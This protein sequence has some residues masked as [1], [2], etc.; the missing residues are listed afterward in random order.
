MKCLV[1]LFLTAAM[2]GG[3]VEGG[4]D[5]E[6]LF[7]NNCGACHGLERAVVGPSL[8]DIR[9]LYEGKEG[10]FVAWAISPQKKRQNVIE[11]PSMVHVGEEGLRAIYGYV[12]KI[13]KG[14][15]VQEEV[16][17]D[18]FLGTPGQLVRPQIQRIFL[19]DAGP[20]AIAVAL[21]EKV[22]LCW[23]AGGARLR[24]AWVGGF[25]DGFPYWWGNGSELAAVVGKVRYREVGSP[26]PLVGEAKFLGYSVKNGLP[27][28]R[29]RVGET[30]V[31]E[32]FTG[33]K[34]EDGFTREFTIRPA[35]EGVVVLDFPSDQAVVITS[36]RGEMVGNC[37]KLAPG[38]AARFT[39]TFSLK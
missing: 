37:L 11:M 7:N 8:A 10:E 27:I 9:G 6:L 20:A 23:D 30:E 34:G 24:Y 14:A 21:D 18:A 15:K 33:V 25:I 1:V 38:E 17:G 13:S 22:S 12:M 35:P 4:L 36:D 29:Y 3:D 16:K 31:T 19:P 32:G 5:G 26:L 2:A 39:L 28:F